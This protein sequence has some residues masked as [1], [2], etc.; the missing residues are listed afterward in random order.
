MTSFVVFSYPED[1]LPPSSESPMFF[2]DGLR[3]H[4]RRQPFT[5]T[6]SKGLRKM[7]VGF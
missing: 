6:I 4:G 3:D 5:N 2:V 7:Q 1:D